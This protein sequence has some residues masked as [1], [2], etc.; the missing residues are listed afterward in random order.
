M[1]PVRAS[2]TGPISRSGASTTPLSSATSSSRVRTGSSSRVRTIPSSAI[3]RLSA[4]AI[5]RPLG[6]ATDRLKNT[7]GVIATATANSGHAV[8]AHWAVT[9][10]ASATK[11]A[12]SRALAIRMAYSAC[13]PSKGRATVPTTQ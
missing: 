12:H 11:A 13:A 2:Q 4:A 7:T 3:H 9:Q 1:S 10:P 8:R 5:S 6:A